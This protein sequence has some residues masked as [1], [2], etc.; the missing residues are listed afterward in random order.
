MAKE[1][2]AG[3]GRERGGDAAAAIRRAEDEADGAD[4][5][6]HFESEAAVVAGADRGADCGVAGAV[7]GAVAAVRGGYLPAATDVVSDFLRRRDAVDRR[8]C[9]SAQS[10]R[11]GVEPGR[12]AL[13][14]V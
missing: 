11:V 8:F 7:H 10:R 1:S 6:R 14:G 9:E 5:R 3:A 13:L 12:A 4:H 2:A